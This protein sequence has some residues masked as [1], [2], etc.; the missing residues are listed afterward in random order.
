MYMFDLVSAISP[1]HGQTELTV[2]FSPNRSV[3]PDLVTVGSG[4]AQSKSASNWRGLWS[5]SRGSDCLRPRGADVAINYLPSEEADAKEV[6]DII[7]EAGRKAA[8][9]PGDLSKE[10]FARKIV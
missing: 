2:A 6:I 10:A 8:A 1:A 9:L 5:W 4:P 3:Q 7:R